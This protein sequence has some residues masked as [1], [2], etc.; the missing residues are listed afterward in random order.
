MN[1]SDIE[2]QVSGEPAEMLRSAFH[3]FVDAGLEALASWLKHTSTHVTAPTVVGK[4]PIGEAAALLAVERSAQAHEIRAAFRARVKA[5]M[6]EGDFHDQAG[7]A[8]DER[9]RQLI[10]AKNLLIEQSR[11]EVVS[12]V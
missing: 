6:D 8:T 2:G 9:A 3:S 7:D 1:R 12:D 5:A 10:A 4:D 11:N